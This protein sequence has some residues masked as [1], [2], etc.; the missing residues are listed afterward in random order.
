MTHPRAGREDRLKG[1]QSF[2]H[3]VGECGWWL[4]GKVTE[5]KLCFFASER[6][7]PHEGLCAE[8][9]I[10]R[11]DFLELRLAPRERCGENGPCVRWKI[12]CLCVLSL[13]NLI[14]SSFR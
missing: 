5:L 7:G 13:L 1:T 11:D 3:G 4:D 10:R 2:S 9:K 14:T 12:N 8:A 6:R